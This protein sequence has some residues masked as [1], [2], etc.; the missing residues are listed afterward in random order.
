MES[1]YFGK[2][3]DQVDSTSQFLDWAKVIEPPIITFARQEVERQQRSAHATIRVQKP[4]NSPGGTIYFGD[5]T[6]AN[7][8][9]GGTM[10]IRR[11]NFGPLNQQAWTR[12]K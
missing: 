6:H 4:A 2:Y 10:W 1:F 5:G 8:P 12:T 3:D 9:A 7:V 11:E